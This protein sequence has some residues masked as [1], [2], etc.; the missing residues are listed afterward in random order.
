MTSSEIE[1]FLM[2]Y[3]CRS[4]SKAAERMYV[5]QSALST[6]LKTLETELGGPLFFREKG[7]RSVVPTEAGDRFFDLAVRYN[8]VV[9]QMHGL[10]RQPDT[11]RLRV[12]CLNSV[13]LYLFTPVYERF[14]Q[15]MPQIVLEMQ[16]LTTSEAYYKVEKGLIDLAF[17]PGRRTSQIVRARPF[18]SEELV[19]VCAKD[20]DYPDTVALSDLD[21][22]NEIYVLWFNEFELWHR[23]T[24]G[25][26]CAPQV[27]L[28]LTGQLPLFLRRK[29][30]WALLPASVAHKILTD[31]GVRRLSRSFEV[32]PRITNCME[33]TAPAK[34]R[35]KG[36]FLDCLREVLTELQD[37]DI[38]LFEEENTK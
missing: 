2:I 27:Y 24:F 1:A 16:D 38:H 10:Y 26:R 29:N 5:S 22:G 12:S 34:A 4:I 17:T 35:L 7:Q 23:H 11:E 31:G 18:F 21:V 30:A 6:R 36:C 13:G 14:M 20:S 28:E 9:Q 8:E 19:L 33:T 32:P 15:K 37:P 25:E 3:E